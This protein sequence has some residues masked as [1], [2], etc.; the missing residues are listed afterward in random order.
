[1]NARKFAL[2]FL[3]VM[4]LGTAGTAHATNYQ[5]R[6]C[7]FP[8]MYWEDANS[9]DYWVLP[10]PEMAYL[11]I[12]AYGVRVRVREG[13]LGQ[14]IY[15]D[16][17]T[18][19]VGNCTT[20]MTLSDTKTYSVVAYSEAKTT[21]NNYVKVVEDDA[22]PAVYWQ[23]LIS[24]FVPDDNETIPL[25]VS[26]P[27]GASIAQVT[28]AASYIVN[29]RPGGVIN[30]TISLFNGNSGC[31]GDGSCA[32]EDGVFLSENGKSHKFIIAHE[33]GHYI[34]ILRDDGG[35]VHTDELLLTNHDCD[36]WTD[37][38]HDFISLEWQNVAAKEG[39]A[40]YYAATVWNDIEESDCEYFYYKTIWFNKAGQLVHVPQN[41]SCESGNNYLS[42]NCDPYDDNQSLEYDWLRFWWDLMTDDGVTFNT[43]MDVWTGSAPSDWEDEGVGVYDALRDAA[44]LESVDLLDWDAQAAYN[45]IDN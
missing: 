23:L 39:F 28:T 44:D 25:W 41:Y 29:K 17:A 30:Q 15:Y 20:Y 31:G 38:S 33:L 18:E 26:N 1:M 35:L 7:V 22:T 3:A 6:F 5:V 37:T 14:T 21:T 45:G 16:Y 12:P 11:L 36:E 10:D 19:Y 4:L 9:A 32:R 43:I 27:G 40:H 24:G 13:L 42:A 2:L 8:V 34:G